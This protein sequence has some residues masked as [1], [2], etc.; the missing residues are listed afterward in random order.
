MSGRGKTQ[1]TRVVPAL[2]LGGLSYFA[3]AEFGG[4]LAVGGGINPVPALIALGIFLSGTTLLSCGLIALADLCGFVKAR[5][6]RGNKGKAAFVKSLRQVRRDLIKHGTSLFW[7][8]FKGVPVFS[9]IESSAYVIGPSGSGKTTKFILTN[10]L[11]LKG[12]AKVVYDF[13]SDI[14]PQILR[15][16][17]KGGRFRCKGGAQLRVINLGGLYENEI[18][19]ETDC[20]NPLIVVMET[21]F[22]KGGLEE[23]TDVIRELC[24][25]LDPDDAKASSGAEG[26]FWKNNNRRWIGFVIQIV[27]LVE[28]DNATLGLCLQMLND[29]GHLLKMAQW[30]AGRLEI[31]TVDEYGEITTSATAIPLH[32]SPWADVHDPADLA[33]YAEFLRG[34]AAG[35]CDMLEAPDSR[36]VDGILAGAQGSALSSFD[37]TTRA[38]KITSKTT[39]R[40]AELKDKGPVTSVCIM[41]DPNKMAAQSKVLGVLNWCMLLELKRHERKTAPVYVLVD[42]AGNIP[43]RDLEGDLTWCRAYSIKLIFAFQNFPAFEKKHGKAALECLLSEAQTVLIMPGQRNPETLSMTERMLSNQSIVTQSHNSNKASGMLT[44]D[45][46]GLQEDA[47]PLMSAEEIRTTTKGLLRMGNN[48]WMQVDLYSIAEIHPWRKQLAP[49]PFTGK[50]YLKRIKLR[51]KLYPRSLLSWLGSVLKFVFTGGRI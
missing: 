24:F 22:R 7:G 13:K 32:E 38:N 31:E 39:F 9:D 19:Q 42:E 26:S 36:M 45:G 48:K 5:M 30:A 17:R 23:I 21:Y 16:L 14:T 43:W 6:P 20:Y 15:P 10:I 49:S 46:Y 47:K 8:T 3:W 40:F 44:M 2:V 27:V 33:N 51:I 37:I 1:Q 4:P 34:L 12:K 50:P 41:L 29:R 18:G 35:I 28:G 11:A 25:I